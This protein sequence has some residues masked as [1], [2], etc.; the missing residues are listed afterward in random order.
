LFHTTSELTTPVV[1]FA[2]SRVPPQAR[3]C[4]LDAGKS[5]CTLPSVAPSE[6][7][8]SPAAAVTVAP[9]A[10]A[11][12]K[13]WSKAVRACAVQASSRCPQLML[14][15]TGVVS[16]CAAWLSASRNPASVFGA[17]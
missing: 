9:S 3:A 5:V 17:K 16:A 14:I 4:G 8:S 6:L 2:S 1:G 12:V 15:A 7:P 11:S 10:A 13:A